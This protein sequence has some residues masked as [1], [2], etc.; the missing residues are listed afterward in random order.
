MSITY[1]D[2]IYRCIVVIVAVLRCSVYSNTAI[3]RDR[4][5]IGIERVTIILTGKIKCAT[6]C[7]TGDDKIAFVHAI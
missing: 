2:A 5:F 6:L 7:S 4:A 1:L 3:N